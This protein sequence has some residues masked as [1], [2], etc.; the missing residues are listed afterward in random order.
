MG[1]D[2]ILFNPDSAIIFFS[3]A[4]YF[5]SI[6]YEPYFLRGTAHVIIDS[7]LANDSVDLIKGMPDFI[8]CISLK[9]SSYK[10]FPDTSILNFVANCNPRPSEQ[11]DNQFDLEHVQKTV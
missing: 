6:Y 2:Y 11:L 1:F 5:D 4:I 10:I 3:Q 8:K 9:I 7:Y